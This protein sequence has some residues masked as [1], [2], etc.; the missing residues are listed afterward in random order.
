MK[1]IKNF[2]WGTFN[3]RNKG[4]KWYRWPMVGLDFAKINSGR[5]NFKQ[6]D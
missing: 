1:W 6:V 2:I 4:I 3:Y 5:Y